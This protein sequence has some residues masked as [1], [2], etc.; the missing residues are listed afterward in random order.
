MEDIAGGHGL[1]PTRARVL[2]LLLDRAVPMSSLDVAAA[3]EMHANGVRFHLDALVRAGFAERSSEHTGTQGRPKVLYAAT[4]EAPD[5][6][7]DHLRELLRVFV[8][9]FVV[10]LPDP[11]VQAERAGRT[12]G[13]SAGTVADEDAVASLTEHASQLGFAAS[14]PRPDRLCFQRCP[15]PVKS[16]EELDPIC[17][18]HL[19]MMRGYLEA[20]GSDHTVADLQRG[21]QECVATLV[22]VEK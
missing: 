19:G 11:L 3:L 6:T 14:N 4:R 21:D 9:H 10:A 7:S 2:K 17:A 8:D 18:V 12:W 1:G 15:Y 16:G 5:V 20:A 22:P 13:R